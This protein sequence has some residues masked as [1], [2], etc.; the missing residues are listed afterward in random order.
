MSER[1]TLGNLFHDCAARYGD[2]VAVTMAP[3]GTSVTYAELETKINQFAHGFRTEFSEARNYVG[4]MLEN[5]I[6]YL[7][8]SYA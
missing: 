6:E 7:I 3:S 4:I 2:R 5:S 1:I 8:A